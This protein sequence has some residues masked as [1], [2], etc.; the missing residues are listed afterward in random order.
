MNILNY[1][2]DHVGE[3]IA[4][5]EFV[6]YTPYVFKRARKL[7][8]VEEEHYL[9]SVGPEQFLGNILCG[10]LASMRGSVI[11]SF[12]PYPP[13]HALPFYFLS[14]LHGKYRILLFS[15]T[16]PTTRYLLEKVEAFSSPHTMEDI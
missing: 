11:I 4:E 1:I 10:N 3:N 8:G 2:A 5:D 12:H 6:T 7:D 14:H 16:L 9:L 13:L 15:H